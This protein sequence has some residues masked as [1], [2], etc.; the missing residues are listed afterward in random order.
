VKNA[1]GKKRAKNAMNMTIASGFG[2]VIA[3]L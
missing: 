1:A 2:W 3:V